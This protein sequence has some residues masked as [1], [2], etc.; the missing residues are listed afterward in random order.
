M[1]LRQLEIFTAVATAGSFTA[2]AKA[3]NMAQPAVSIAIRKLEEV[4][5]TQLLSRGDTI[6]PTAEGEVLLQHARSLLDGVQA[7]RQQM[8]ELNGL[9]RGEVRF[10]TSAMLGSY[11]FVPLIAAFRQRYPGVSLRVVNEGTRGAR[12]WLEEGA[13]DLAVVNLDDLPADVEAM[14]LTRQ[15]VVA[16]VHQQHPLAGS[17]V[18]RFADL[19]T[20]PLAI[21]RKNY[22]LRRLLDQ[23]SERYQVAPNIAMETDLLGMIL[24]FV[25]AAEGV[26]LC[27]RTL[28]DNEPD[29]VA[30]PFEEQVWLAL[31]LGWRQGK[32]LSAANRAFV[33]FLSEA[34]DIEDCE[35]LQTLPGHRS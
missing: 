25:R 18:V 12:H 22:A 6:L 32:Y 15:E 17:E 13:S 33:D 26:T 31:G 11:F 2:A 21:Y 28:V 19:A 14:P 16:C 9:E 4:L 20:M 8:A 29:L 35:N 27:L 23:L 34:L 5:D 10:S 30:I 3:L 24:G 7:A 1:N